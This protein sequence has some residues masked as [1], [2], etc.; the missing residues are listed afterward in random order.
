MRI[1]FNG[2]YYGILRIDMIDGLRRYMEI[3]TTT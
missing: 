2:E 1:L 3:T